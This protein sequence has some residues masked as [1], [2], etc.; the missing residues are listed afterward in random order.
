MPEIVVCQCERC[1]KDFKQSAWRSV[2][3]K[4]RTRYCGRKCGQRQHG[5]P[6]QRFWRK[7]DKKGPLKLDTRCWQWTG[8]K[9]EW[10]HGRIRQG[11]KKGGRMVYAHRV[12]WEMHGNVLPQGNILCHKCHNPAC[13]NPAHLYVGTDSTNRTDD[14]MRG[15][16]HLAKIKAE[17]VRE[18]RRQIAEL[19]PGVPTFKRL[20]KVY[21]V[22]PATI[23]H[24]SAGRTWKRVA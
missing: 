11:G 18:I 21:G 14:V 2:H 17:Q 8:V 16:H 4:Y 10:G 6:E 5:T 24:I 12:S 9:S 13:V 3:P 7:V 23:Y 22:N 19:G 20:A 15:N 1:G